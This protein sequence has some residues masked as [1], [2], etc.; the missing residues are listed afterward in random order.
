M[1]FS[2][3]ENFDDVNQQR[4]N[5]V[6]ST[7][8]FNNSE[9]YFSLE[10]MESISLEAS[11]LINEI[12]RTN[13]VYSGLESLH[14]FLVSNR[15]NINSTS[16][17]LT[18]LSLEHLASELNT[19][20]NVNQLP[21]NESFDDPF[22][23]ESALAI[24]LEGIVSSMK[25][26]AKKIGEKIKQFI[27]WMGEKIVNWFNDRRLNKLKEII[28]S[29]KN[30]TLVLKSKEQLDE[31]KPMEPKTKP[32]E[33]SKALKEL[34]SKNKGISGNGDDP[35]AI[36]TEYI[37]QH[38]QNF[39]YSIKQIEKVFKIVNSDKTWIP[40]GEMDSEPM[41]SDLDSKLASIKSGNYEE[42]SLSK[43]LLAVLKSLRNS[44]DSNLSNFV[45]DPYVQKQI[46]KILDEELEF[47]ESMDNMYTFLSQ[48]HSDDIIY[49]GF[50]DFNKTVMNKI[51]NEDSNDDEVY[52]KKYFK[53]TK[54]YR[55]GHH[56][57][58]DDYLWGV[59]NP[60]NFNIIQWFEEYYEKYSLNMKLMK[61][62]INPIVGDLN[63]LGDFATNVNREKHSIIIGILRILSGLVMIFLKVFFTLWKVIGT[64]AETPFYIVSYFFMRKSF[65]EKRF[66][67]Y[68]EEKDEWIDKFYSSL[69]P[70]DKE[71]YRRAADKHYN[72]S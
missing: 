13:K 27:K 59:R 5:E 37:K 55:S 36:V 52:L 63:K 7:E 43:S 6:H 9:V 28:I 34:M 51:S 4:Q 39:K 69:S 22:M 70:S 33:M 1:L 47:L 48:L 41:K 61:T 68:E 23:K 10:T 32:E 20:L 64:M 44:T 3:L 21:A 8:G 17:G 56:L 71:Y 42:G 2:A 11:K 24:S 15:V 67:R 12:D 30:G 62:V 54:Q 14:D 38:D 16:L 60:A 50:A 58:G 26:V 49:Y 65:K 66:Q 25:D 35:V 53:D 46:Y 18:K 19:T 57:K 72:D 29:L 45:M 31:Q 40:K